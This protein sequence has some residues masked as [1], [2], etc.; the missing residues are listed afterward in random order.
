MPPL[1]QIIRQSAP[2]QLKKLPLLFMRV[3]LNTRAPHF[4]N[5]SYVP[6]TF[7][8]TLKK[9]VVFLC[10]TS[11]QLLA[12]V[13][14][15]PSKCIKIYL[16]ERKLRGGSVLQNIDILKSIGDHKNGNGFF[17]KGITSGMDNR[18]T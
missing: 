16:E 8:S 13:Y 5:A 9:S 6:G 14:G 15:P 3:L 2:L 10:V 11:E 18:I 17:G 7:Q 4:L 1:S 12:L